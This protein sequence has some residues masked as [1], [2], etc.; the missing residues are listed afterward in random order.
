MLFAFIFDTWI[1]LLLSLF[2]AVFSIQ[3]PWVTTHRL[4]VTPRE[5]A[6][7]HGTVSPAPPVWGI[8]L[9]SSGFRLNH[10][11][12]SPNQPGPLPAPSNWDVG[13][14]NEVCL[15]TGVECLVPVKLSPFFMSGI[16]PSGL[17]WAGNRVLWWI[18]NDPQ[19]LTMSIGN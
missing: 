17:S 13:V 15:N 12:K 11:V 4:L 1:L 10:T 6:E 3:S 7:E 9:L 16:L 8:L 5:M 2:H 18:S 14:I 19:L